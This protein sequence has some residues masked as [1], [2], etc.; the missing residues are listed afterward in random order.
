VINRHFDPLEDMT[1]KATIYDL[2]G[3]VERTQKQTL[4]AGANACTDAFTLDFPATGAHLVKLEL[5]DS[6]GKLLSQNLYWHARDERQLQSL[7]SLPQ[8]ELKGKWHRRQGENGWVIEGRIKNSS[9]VP[10]LEARLT[11]RD[12]KTGQ[13]VLPVYY[14]DNYISLLPRESRDFEIET[15][16][17][18][19][20]DMEVTL[21]GWNVKPSVL[22]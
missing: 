3:H 1:A 2:S 7:N 11:L 4:T 10:V 12:A 9:H 15:R 22:K 6:H 5:L 16:D 19:P 13:R 18:D 8:V 17:N 14:N 21:D 20:S